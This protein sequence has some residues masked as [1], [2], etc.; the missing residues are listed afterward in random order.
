VF[1]DTSDFSTARRWHPRE[2]HANTPTVDR[3]VRTLDLLVIS[4]ALNLSPPPSTRTPFH[5][6]GRR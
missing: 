6:N 3:I 1:T 4:A 2:A 5:P